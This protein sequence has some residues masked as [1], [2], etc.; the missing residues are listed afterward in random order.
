MTKYEA[1]GTGFGQI[2]RGL[3]DRGPGT[4]LSLG[5]QA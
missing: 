2:S 5:L 1:L 4:S 3:G